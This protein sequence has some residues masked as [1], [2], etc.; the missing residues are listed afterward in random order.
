MGREAQLLAILALAVAWGLTGCVDADGSA[1]GPQAVSGSTGVPAD[2]PVEVSALS[3]TQY[4]VTGPYTYQNVAVFLLHTDEQD[5]REF[6]TLHEGLESGQVTVTEKGEGDVGELLLTNASALPLFLHEGDRF[7]GGKQDRTLYSSLVIPPN[8]RDAPIPT[9]CIEQGRWREDKT[10]KG[11]VAGASLALAPKSVRRAAKYSKD[12]NEVWAQ[13]AVEKARASA[14]LGISA[15][16]SSLN[17]AMDS[18]VMR[19]LA[20]SYS[21]RLGDAVI[22]KKDAV[23]VAIVINGKIEEIDA[24]PNHGLLLKLYPRLLQ[25]FALQAVTSAKDAPSDRSV[26][27]DEIL[28]FMQQMKSESRRAEQLNQRNQVLLSESAEAAGA[29]TMYED[30]MVHEQYMSKE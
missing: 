1:G 26:T 20:E 22:G 25:S 18:D 21:K 12:Q 24:Y 29:V 4:R 2:S 14:G 3:E 23:G 9:F 11:F 13:V 8:T 6:L 16:T 17:E 30:A 5:D 19:R 28:A 27:G 7:E 15:E 10:G